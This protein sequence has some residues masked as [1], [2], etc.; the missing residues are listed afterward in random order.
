M[1][2]ST[3]SRPALTRRRVL[4]G[5]GLGVLA[6]VGALRAFNAAGTPRGPIKT[7]EV[8]H[9]DE[10]WRHLLSPQQYEV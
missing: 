1:T 6:G 5:T 9:T 2:A 10:E 3:P 4:L 8:N 7:F